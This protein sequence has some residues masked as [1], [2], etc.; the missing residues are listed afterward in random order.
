MEMGESEEYTHKDFYEALGE[1]MRQKYA[2]GPFGQATISE[3]V[4]GL[5]G[6]W[7]YENVRKILANERGL[8]MRFIEDC[9]R[10]FGKDPSYFREYRVDQLNTILKD[11]PEVLAELYEMAL[12]L[13]ARMEEKNNKK[14]SG[15]LEDS[16]SSCQDGT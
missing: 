13:A 1:L 12:D 10:L 14:S 4:R 8:P 2:N 15:G 3:L 16:D 7:H 5:G 6:E 9:A 11:Y